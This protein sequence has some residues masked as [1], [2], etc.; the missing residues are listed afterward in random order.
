VLTIGPVGDGQAADVVLLGAVL[1]AVDVDPQTR[2]VLRWRVLAQHV[3]RSALVTAQVC[4]FEGTG[5]LRILAAL[6]RD[7]VPVGPPRT[8]ELTAQLE[9]QVLSAVI[10]EASARAGPLSP[11]SSNWAGELV[12]RYAAAA[13]A[14]K[15]P[16]G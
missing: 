6:D 13:A 8:Y 3:E 15:A 1:V 5:A 7:D 10:R 14:E 11:V 16:G 2:V 4:R 12:D 9:G